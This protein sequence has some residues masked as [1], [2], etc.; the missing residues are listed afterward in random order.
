MCDNAA[1]TLHVD[2]LLTK[3]NPGPSTQPTAPQLVEFV[4]TKPK[5]TAPGA[6]PGGRDSRR[7]LVK[8]KGVP[9]SPVKEHR[10]VD[11]DDDEVLVLDSDEESDWSEIEN[12][13]L[14]KLGS[15]PS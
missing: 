8:Q 1:T 13:T 10:L 3:P 12:L 7:L 6:S 2:S 11:S 9:P 15:G 14:G 5:L 4:T